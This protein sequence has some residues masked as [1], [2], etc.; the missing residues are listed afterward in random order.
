MKRLLQWLTAVVLVMLAGPSGATAQSAKF[1]LG[2]GLVVPTS[3]YNTIDKTG[4]HVLGKVDF[5]IPMSPIGVR[6]DAMY[7]QTSHKDQ[8]GVA[9]PGNT[10]LAGGTAGVVWHIPTAVPG[11]KPYLLASG[12]VYNFK[13]TF[14]SSPG[15]SEV[16]ET[17]FTWGAGVGVTIGVGPVHGFVEGRYM[18]IQTSATAVKFIPLTVGVTF[19]SK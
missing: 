7:G 5:G 14:P 12:G 13:Q 19:G 15:T 17:K 18:S 9:V 4:W 2:G 1:G 6:V 11:F 3:D 16:S 10:K 8:G